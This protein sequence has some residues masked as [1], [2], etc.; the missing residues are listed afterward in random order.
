[1]RDIKP[2]NILLDAFD[3]PVFA[4]FGIAFIWETTVHWGT[5]IKGTWNYMAP[6]AFDPRAFAEGIGTHTDIWALACVIIEMH[7]GRRPWPGMQ[8]QQ[9]SRA[10]C[11][12]ERTP[13]VPEDA[14]A[15][16]ELR[17]CFE[18]RPTRRPTAE[19]LA[20]AFALNVPE[21]MDNAGLV[22]R[23][24]D[25]EAITQ[26][27][28][29]MNS[30][31]TQETE[32]LRQE[33]ARLQQR[34]QQPEKRP[35]RQ[36]AI[37]QEIDRINSRLTQETAQLRQE[38]AQLQQRVQRSQEIDRINSRLTQETAQLRQENAQ[39]QQRV[40]QLRQ[41]NARLQQ[42]VQ[43]PEQGPGRQPHQEQPP[44]VAQEQPPQ[45]AQEQPPQVAQEQPPPVAQEQP[46]P[47][48]QEQPPPVARGV[49]ARR[50]SG[51]LIPGVNGGNFI[52]FSSDEPGVGEKMFVFVNSS[53]SWR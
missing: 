5:S 47:V 20:Q 22:R 42:R 29:R 45:V 17:R 36:Q 51:P 8:M 21:G 53:F 15:A 26:E 27:I 52:Y 3:Q 18:Y 33:N 25:Q 43:Q 10:V 32:Q 48:A 30:R 31:L 14:G 7:T 2:Q 40:Q 50:R 13:S 16:P 38:N 44:P 24:A 19:E 34:V 4:D 11:D 28:T 49:A 35:R 37:T 9:I 41:E 6:E 1:M 46:P 23:L 12:L 39:L